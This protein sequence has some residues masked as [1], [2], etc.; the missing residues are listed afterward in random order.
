MF[1]YLVD[2]LRKAGVG[3]E[4]LEYFTLHVVQ[5]LEHGKLLRAALARYADT[6]ENQARIRDGALAF[7]DARARFWNGLYRAVFE[8]LSAS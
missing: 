2:G 7:L 6:P 8:D 1:T 4:P 5:D 3:E